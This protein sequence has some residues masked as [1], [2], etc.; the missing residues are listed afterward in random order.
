LGRFFETG[1]P[2]LSGAVAPRCIVPN[3]SKTESTMD[4]CREE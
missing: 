3:V 2:A 4:V 1:L